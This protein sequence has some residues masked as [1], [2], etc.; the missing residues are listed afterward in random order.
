M[1]ALTKIWNVLDGKM[2]YDKWISLEKIYQLVKKHGN[3]DESDHA[4]PA[5]WQRKVREV[6]QERIQIGQ[7]RWDGNAKYKLV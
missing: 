6:L 5:L 3:L 4:I 2:P 7:I 1:I